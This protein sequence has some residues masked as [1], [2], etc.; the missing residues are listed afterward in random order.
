MRA[1]VAA[2]A[3]AA[4]LA[5][6]CGSAAA[7][8]E[9]GGQYDGQELFAE[10]CGSCHVL[11]DAGTAG[12]IGPN[13]DQ[14]FDDVRAEGFDETT[15]RDLVRGQ[16]EYPTESPSS[17]DPGMP[18]PGT[19]L[20]G[21]D[22]RDAAADAI[23]IYVASVAGLPVAEEE[24]DG[25]AAPT[26]PKELFA[27]NGCGGC[28]VLAD[29]GT[30]GTIGPNLDQTMPALEAAIEQITNGGGGM[31]AFG[32]QLSAGQIRALAEYIV[33]VAGG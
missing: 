20:A 30:S 6:G 31:P 8:E 13:L 24:G 26:D 16:I 11:A 5:A 28:H 3:L 18:G 9:A 23:A 19:T 22:D 29:A 7:G 33:R 4:V 15:I 12:V 14:A 21:L 10:R 32:D 2:V 25:E 17:G 1:A 27:A